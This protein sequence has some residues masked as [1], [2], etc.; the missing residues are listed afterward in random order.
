MITSNTNKILVFYVLTI[1]LSLLIKEFQDFY[2]F[3]EHINFELIIPGFVVILLFV[4][5]D[6]NGDYKG[7]LQR[8][9][10][11][12]VKPTFFQLLVTILPLIIIPLSYYIYHKLYS[13]KFSLE[14]IQ[15]S[16]LL[17]PIIGTFSEELGWRG[18]LQ[19]KSGMGMHIILSTLLTGTMWFFWQFD[20]YIND[21]FY[22]VICYVL[23]ISLSFIL[24]YLFYI[25]NRNIIL[26]YIFRLLF[27]ILAIIFISQ[28]SQDIN[29]MFILVPIFIIIAI[30]TILLNKPLFQLDRSNEL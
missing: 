21:I 18:Y 3:Y 7:F 14:T 23:I 28:T 12:S 20:L 11:P 26:S 15:I 5:F 25:S 2:K 13:T 22:G 27:N 30:T 19:Y 16:S 24:A 6:E 29:F 17:W 1:L 9:I 8:R 4:L 10:V